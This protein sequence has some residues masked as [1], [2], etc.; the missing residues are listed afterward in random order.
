MLLAANVFNAFHRLPQE[1]QNTSPRCREYRLIE[2]DAHC[3]Q[4]KPVYS[5]G[6]SASNSRESREPTNSKI[7]FIVQSRTILF[8]MPPRALF[9]DALYTLVPAN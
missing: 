9:F 5:V 8:Q 4:I 7:D 1:L 6:P 3:G 2:G